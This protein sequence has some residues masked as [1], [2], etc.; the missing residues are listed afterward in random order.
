[1]KQKGDEKRSQIES[2]V[3]TATTLLERKKSIQLEKF[4]AK[5]NK[6]NKLQ[7]DDILAMAEIRKLKAAALI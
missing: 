6:A 5:I 7:E 2:V 4:E 3:D 1:M